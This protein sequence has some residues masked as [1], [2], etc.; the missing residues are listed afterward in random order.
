MGGPAVRAMI[1]RIEASSP[2]ADGP[3]HHARETIVVEDEMND[4][5][6]ID[7]SDGD[8]SEDEAMAMR[9]QE[10][11]VQF[12]LHRIRKNKAEKSSSSR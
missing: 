11:E 10:I 12:E 5:I 2:S 1:T 7:S 9:A 4:D 6:T 3:N 8:E